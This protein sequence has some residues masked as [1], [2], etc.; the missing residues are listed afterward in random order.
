[1]ME[2]E[3]WHLKRRRELEAAP[4]VKRKPQVEPFV[5]VPL[6]WATAASKATRDRGMLVCIELLRASWKAK[7]LTFSLPNGRLKRA[8]VSRKIKSRVLRDL[9]RARLIVVERRPRKTPIITLIAL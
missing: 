9:E 8:G 7:S 1:M 6:W 5:K 3:P 4:P 2:D